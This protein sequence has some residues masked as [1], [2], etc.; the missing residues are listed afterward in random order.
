[1]DNTVTVAAI[2][3]LVTSL[4]SKGAEGPAHTINLLWKVTLGRWDKPLERYIE[5][6]DSDKEKYAEEIL[7][8][9]NKIPADNIKL[10]ADIS[11][12]GPALEASKYYIGD[13]VLRSMF[14]KLI[15][16]SMDSRHNGEVH[17]AFVEIIKQMNPIDAKVLADLKDSSHVLYCTVKRQETTDEYC[18][19]YMSNRFPEPS[20]ESS[21]A[22]SNLERLGLIHV[23]RYMQFLSAEDDIILKSLVKKFKSTN[24]YKELPDTD[25][26]HFFM[27][28]VLL[29]PLGVKFR[30]ICL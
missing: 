11:I 28:E 10:E 17:H 20:V 8:E 6:R 16:A 25:N 5:R 14:A 18:D 3:A 23:S 7:K 15:A 2:T 19:L 26:A 24:Y 21:L 4:A 22:I 30:N 1:M 9:T 13:A 29:T 27:N 12:I